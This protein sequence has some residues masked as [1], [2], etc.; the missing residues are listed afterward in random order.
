MFVNAFVRKEI[1]LRPVNLDEDVLVEMNET[2]SA[3]KDSPSTTLGK[4]DAYHALVK[5]YITKLNS[6]C[7]FDFY[8]FLSS[9]QVRR[10]SSPRSANSKIREGV[11]EELVVDN[12]TGL[13]TN[14][15]SFVLNQVNTR[16][17]NWLFMFFALCLLTALLSAL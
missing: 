16:H 10:E 7:P 14:A 4:R 15:Y 5:H 12:H 11:T 8:A 2:D 1:T 3:L 6:V 9:Y 17:F 13:I